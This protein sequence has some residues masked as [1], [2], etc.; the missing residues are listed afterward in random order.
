VTNPKKQQI[1]NTARDLFWKYGFRHVSIEEICEE[2]DVRPDINPQFILYFLDK[3]IEICKDEYLM[4]L[5]KRPQDLIPEV[6]RFFFYGILSR[7]LSN[8]NL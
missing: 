6:T 1:T 5:Y 3:I 4:N 2:A 7:K 8:D